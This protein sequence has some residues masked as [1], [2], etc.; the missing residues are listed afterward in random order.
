MKWSKIIDGWSNDKV[1]KYPSNIKN[2]FVWRTSP[3]NNNLSNTYKQEFRVDKQLP[4][5]QD[6]TAFK[7]YFKHSK[8]VVAFLNLS[9]DTILVVPVPRKNKNYATI[10]HFIDNASVSQQKQV[11]KKVAH[12]ARCLSKLQGD[13][14]YIS[15]HG[16][17][18][19]Y[20]HIRIGFTARYY[21]D[22]K[23]K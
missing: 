18:V 13:D 6:Y 2:T 19:P 23:I 15:T 7:K 22:S 14:I 3:I 16:H 9:K 12:V 20:T 17:G 8:D 10:K 11:W 1:L 4:I 21:D 5:H